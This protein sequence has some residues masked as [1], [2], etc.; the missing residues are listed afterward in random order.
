MFLLFNSIAGFL[1][2]TLHSFRS[3][4]YTID[5]HNGS[6]ELI[7]RKGATLSCA[8]LRQMFETKMRSIESFWSLRFVM[9]FDQRSESFFS[10]RK[11]FRPDRNGPKSKSLFAN[12]FGLQTFLPGNNRRDAGVAYIVKKRKIRKL[13]TVREK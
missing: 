7:V 11:V 5:S 6:V 3:Q 1:V 10:G 4:V 8:P 13:R 2:N 9:F 12:P